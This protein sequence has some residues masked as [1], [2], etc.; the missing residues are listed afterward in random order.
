[1]IGP[2]EV[3]AKL[4]VKPEQVRDY[5]ALVG[6]SIDNVPGVPSVGPK[7][8]VQLLAQ[9]GDLDALYAQLDKVEKKGVRQ[10][11]QDHRDDALHEPEARGV[12]RAICDVDVSMEALRLPA[13]DVARLREL[14]TEL[15]FVRLRRPAR[16]GG[17]EGGRGR[18]GTEVEAECTT[19][20]HA[21]AG[22]AAGARGGEQ[23]CARRVQLSSSSACNRSRP[24]RRAKSCATRPR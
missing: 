13:P 4:G 23:P 21:G 10:K 24:V 7:T 18:A 9:F 12:A 17:A 11:L 6:D 5:L 14:F 16:G 15:G 20:P 19:R 22:R 1:M 3:V 8:A 2:D